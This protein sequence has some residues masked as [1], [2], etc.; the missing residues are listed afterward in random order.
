MD[1]CCYFGSYL[2]MRE[3]HLCLVHQFEC[4]WCYAPYMVQLVNTSCFLM[5]FELF[6]LFRGLFQ[7]I[8]NNKPSKIYIFTLDQRS[9]TKKHQNPKKIL[10]FFLKVALHLLHSNCFYW[11]IILDFY[12]SSCRGSTTPKK[13]KLTN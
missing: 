12:I 7:V 13:F 10:I 8:K 3:G 1:F 2:F 6:W 11:K 5:N 9:K 4:F